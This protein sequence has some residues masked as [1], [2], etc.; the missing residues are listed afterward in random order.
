MTKGSLDGKKALLFSKA[1]LNLV[2]R[3]RL[4][5]T[6]NGLKVRCSTD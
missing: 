6:T 1:F 4:E 5:R 3:V 2:G